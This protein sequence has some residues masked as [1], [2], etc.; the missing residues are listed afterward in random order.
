MCLCVP[1]PVILDFIRQ[2]GPCQKPGA[3]LTD[4]GSVKEIICKTAEAVPGLNFIGSHPMAGTEKSGSGAALPHLYHNADVFITPGP[5]AAEEDILFLKEFW[6]SLGT[7]V[8]LIL[9]SEH[10]EL[11]ANSSHMLHIIASALSQSILDAPDPQTQRRHYAGCATGFKDTSRI[12][13]SSPRM[14]REICSSNVPAILNALDAFENRLQAMRQCLEDGRYH[15][16]EVLFTKG[17]YLRDSWLCYK[18]ANPLPRNISLCGI[19]HAGKSTVAKEL[20]SILA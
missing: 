16:F 8:R 6:E 3:L 14:W 5:G 12:A 19:K 17:K 11:V 10:D 7:H 15:D 9:P 18:A 20:A 2:Y 13:S 1:I 4:I